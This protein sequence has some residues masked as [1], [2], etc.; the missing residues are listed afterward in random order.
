MTSLPLA[1]PTVRDGD[2]APRESIA[3]ATA[4]FLVLFGGDALRNSVGWTAWGII[5]GLLAAASIVVSVRHRLP[6]NRIPWP[7]V[8][9]LLTMV[10]SILWSDYPTGSLLGVGSQLMTTA[11]PLAM[12]STLTWPAIVKALGRALR[13]IV[14]LSLLFEL[15]VSLVVR[16]PICPIYTR[17]LCV[18]HY[19]AAFD[20]SRD[21]LLHGG[22]IGGL[23]G[24]SNLLAIFALLALVVTAVEAADRSITRV[25]AWV[26][27]VSAVLAYG[28]T[29]SST[30]LVCTLA[31]AVVLGVALMIRRSSHRMRRMVYPAALVV[32]LALA[33]LALVFNKPLLHLLGKSSTFT[34]RRTIWQSVYELAIQRPVAGW[35]WTGWW[36]P[37]LEPFKGLAVRNGVV[38][39][40][41]HEAYLDMFFQLGWIGLV[42]FLAV[43]VSTVARAWWWATDRRMLAAG[44]PAKW[45]ARDLL[46]ILL[47]AVMLVHGLGES[48]LNVE[49]GWGL[50]VVICLV[51]RVDW[52]RW[53]GGPPPR[54]KTATGDPTPTKAG[55]TT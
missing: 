15:F 28:L 45:S 44:Q 9:L 19:P 49:W 53:Y 55:A 33:A 18:G 37:Y 54:Q 39:L 17:S 13:I 29:R 22:P 24:N 4:L 38:Y 25:T 11:A 16:H 8:A 26:G 42:I 47:L 31:C 5:A 40:Q 48:R 46:P 14:V 35:G 10:L 7:L 32:I 12:A 34:G 51:T 27:I 20:W 50:L 2:H 43:I 30:V 21:N 36:Q 3:L 23:P 6:L 1:R 41:A 52:F